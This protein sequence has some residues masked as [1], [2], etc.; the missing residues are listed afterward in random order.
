MLARKP[1]LPKVK[2][3][4]LIRKWHI[5][6]GDKVEVIRGKEKRKVGVVK[7]L[8]RDSNQVILEGINLVKKHIASREDFKGGIFSIEAP[9]HY[10]NVMLV[11]PKDGRRTRIS[12]K[13]TEEGSKLR[14]SKRTGTVIPKPPIP[15][16]D[17][18]R[19]REREKRG[20]GA[21]DTPL[22]IVKLQ[23]YKSPSIQAKS[24]EDVD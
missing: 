10:S 14:L 9:I 8:M 15:E 24:I 13:Y 4:D 19:Q 16:E 3:R 7:K 22:D 20:I 1:K 21:K 18:K 12:S 5:F 17:L 2:P 23:T 6:K 11:D